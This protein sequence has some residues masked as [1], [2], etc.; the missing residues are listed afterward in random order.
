MK[1]IEELLIE[2]ARDTKVL[3]SLQFASKILVTD[4]GQMV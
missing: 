4:N 2:E 3:Q 1:E